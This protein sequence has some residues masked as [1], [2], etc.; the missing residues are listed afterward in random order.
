V[1]AGEARVHA[2]V[3]ETPAAEAAGFVDRREP[4]NADALTRLEPVG[5]IPG[6]LDMP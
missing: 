6:A 1:K 5:A 2:Q 3:L 4:G